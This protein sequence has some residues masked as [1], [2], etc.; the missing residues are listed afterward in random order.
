MAELAV[1]ELLGL[2]P[3]D[4]AVDSSVA[5]RILATGRMDGV[6]GGGKAAPRLPGKAAP[7]LPGTMAATEAAEAVDIVEATPR[8]PPTDDARVHETPPPC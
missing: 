3:G 7:Q 4:L 6:L 5:R 8:E 1:A 2:P